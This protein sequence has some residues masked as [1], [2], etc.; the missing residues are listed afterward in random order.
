[1]SR[2]TLLPLRHSTLTKWS[3]LVQSN[4]V[5]AT[6]TFQEFVDGLESELAVCEEASKD[7]M[8]V[9]AVRSS[10]EVATND[11]LDGKDDV[12]LAPEPDFSYK[13]ALEYL[14]KMKA[15]CAKNSLSEKSLQCL[16]FV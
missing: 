8:I 16:S 15:Y 5:T 6:D 7:D 11:Y 10:A 12:D 14:T 4:F 13:G 1:M 9:T 3:G 2:A